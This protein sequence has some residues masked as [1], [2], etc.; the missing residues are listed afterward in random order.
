M[1]ERRAGSGGRGPRAGAAGGQPDPRSEG[2]T[3]FGS[4]SADKALGYIEENIDIVLSDLNMGDVSG[5]GPA[6]LWKKRQPETQFILVSGQATRPQRRRGD[7]K[8]GRTTT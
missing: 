3:V 8:R 1:I 2:F 5:H 7:E 6:Q 4:E